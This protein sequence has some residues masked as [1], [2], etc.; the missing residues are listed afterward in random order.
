MF[1]SSKLHVSNNFITSA[2][3][4]RILSTKVRVYDYF[5]VRDVHGIFDRS[6]T[7]S[8]L[9]ASLAVNA[10]IMLYSVV[11]RVVWAN[12]IQDGHRRPRVDMDV[13]ATT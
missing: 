10:A 2:K 8:S 13:F 5:S 4:L 12:Y 6:L 9:N 1:W 3:T 11:E 7:A